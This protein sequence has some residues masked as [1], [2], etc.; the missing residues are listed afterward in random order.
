VRAYTPLYPPDPDWLIE[1]DQGGTTA[2]IDVEVTELPGDRRLR[3]AWEHVT[4]RLQERGQQQPDLQPITRLVFLADKALPP[5]NGCDNFADELAEFATGKAFQECESVEV[6]PPFGQQFPLMS[7]F[8]RK[9][10]LRNSGLASWHCSEL[11]GGFVGLS[12]DDLARMMQTK[13]CKAKSYSRKG[14]DGLW[15]LVVSGAEPEDICASSGDD[16]DGRVGN[17]I[18]G[19]LASIGY[20]IEPFSELFFYDCLFGIAY[21]WCPSRDSIIKLSPDATGESPSLNIP[22]CGQVVPTARFTKRA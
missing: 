10:H 20:H 7:R 12:V 4:S 14:L 5:A 13:K 19:A 17:M 9:I 22:K 8:V 16:F 11:M 15:L 3:H 21:H 18:H 2:R 6:E 1:L